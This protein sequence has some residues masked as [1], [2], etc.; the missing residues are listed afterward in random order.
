MARACHTTCDRI[1]IPRRP[2]TP[3]GHSITGLAAIP[4]L[5][6]ECSHASS[7][8]VFETVGVIADADGSLEAG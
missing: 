5:G 1:F 4:Q 6:R 7:S 3:L 8:P 2:A